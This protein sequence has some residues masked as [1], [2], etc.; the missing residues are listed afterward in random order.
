[1]DEATFKRDKITK[2]RVRFTHED[3]GDVEGAL[4]LKPSVAAELPER[5]TVTLKPAE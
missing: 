5:V 4:Y 3:R 2:Q 1:M